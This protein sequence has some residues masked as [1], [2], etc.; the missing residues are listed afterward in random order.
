M[1]FRK[2]RMKAESSL[3][4][5]GN[6]KEV[7]RRAVASGALKLS[8]RSLKEIAQRRNYKGDILAAAEV[9]G[10][11]AAKQTSSLIPFCHQIP[12]TSVSI[13]FK[14]TEDA[15]RCRAVVEA[16]WKTGVEMEAIV[17]VSIALVTVWDMVKRYEKDRRG[18]YPDTW[19]ERISVETK[20]KER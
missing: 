2:G 3:V 13:G 18:Q 11:T 19:I 17:A 20:E 8:R 9:A 1:A 15:I 16:E 7:W 12:L 14:E 10:I 6:K 4:D 5:I